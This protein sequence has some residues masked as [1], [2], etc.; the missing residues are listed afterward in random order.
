M[1]WVETTGSTV[2]EAKEA[3]LDQLGIDSSEAEFEILEEPKTGLFGR[4]RGTA[5]VRARVVPKSPRPKQERRPRKARAKSD[6]PKAAPKAKASAAT[7]E[8]ADASD[9]VSEGAVEAVSAAG[10]TSSDS[11]ASGGRRGSRGLSGPRS[12]GRATDNQEG[13]EMSDDVVSVDEQADIIS[14]FLEG[15]LGSLG[16]EGDIKRTKVDDD[17]IELGV[18]GDDLGLLIGPKGQT[19]T[20]VH[21][22]SRTVLQR[23]ATG[24]HDGRVRIDIGGYRQRRQEA[25]ARFVRQQAE[26]VVAQ[27]V[28]RAL[29]PMNAVDRKVV[30]DTINEIDGVSTLSEGIDPNRRVVIVVEGTEA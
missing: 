5:R 14:E 24:R 8:P 27:G 1:Q 6:G 30:H 7:A 28:S 23:R 20:A 17:T 21:E 13:N 25:L 15:L 19:L 9:D 11:P 29:E 10:A 2:E 4:I 26:E 16:I 18:E 3:A 22:L 12:G